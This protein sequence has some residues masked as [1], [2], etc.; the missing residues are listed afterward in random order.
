MSVAVASNTTEKRPAYQPFQCT[1][2]QSRFTRQENLK[3]HAVLHS[4]S[5]E[6]SLS[7]N[8]CQATFSRPDL[9]TRHVKRKHPG[10]H[11]DHC[12]GSRKRRRSSPVESQQDTQQENSSDDVNSVLNETTNVETSSMLSAPFLDPGNGLDSPSMEPATLLRET[13]ETTL[14]N[15]NFDQWSPD[16]I[17]TT[18]RIHGQDDWYPSETQIAHGRYLFFDHVSQFIPIIHRATFD[19]TRIAQHLLLSMLCLAYQHG[20]DPDRGD[21]LGSGE[22]L[23]SHCFHRARELIAAEEKKEDEGIHS[24]TMVQAYL[25]LQIFAMMYSRGNDSP[26]GLKTHSKMIALA[27]AGGLM[28]PIQIEANETEDLD[29]LWRQFIKAESHKRTL[30]AIHQLDTLWY[31][32]LSIPRSLSHLEIK[33]D[34]PCPTDQWLASSSHEW[35][36]RQLVARNSGPPVRYSDAVRRFLSSG[37]DLIPP[38]DPYGAINITQFLISSAREVSGWSTMT[39]MVS[40]ERLEPL[41]SSLLALN[42]C[43]RTESDP[44]PPPHAPLHEV[45]WEIAM[46]EMQMWSPSHTG[47]IVEGSIDAALHGMSFLS[48]STELLRE[49]SIAESIRPHVDWFLRYLDSTPEPYAEA[50]WITL[51]AYKAFMIAW[52]LFQADILEA[53]QVVGIANGDVEAGL[54]WAKKVF[55]CRERWKLG[56][57][58]LACLEELG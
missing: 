53:L 45:T 16:A 40:I 11:E 37:A 9:R 46:I 36:H 21:Q 43:I 18:E 23:S 10:Y 55:G 29:S 2:C 28:Q 49:S 30:F 48:P 35:A 58:V 52:Q 54:A 44:D 24:T 34:L 39:G 41:R 33:H 12:H 8:L 4:K 17:M 25:M 7:C 3:R 31:Q 57:I 42:S 6:A 15:F 14:A 51:Y 5:S 47:G 50:P 1:I 13:F 32:F 38:F 22:E 26:Y 56:R 19:A 27:R 20:E